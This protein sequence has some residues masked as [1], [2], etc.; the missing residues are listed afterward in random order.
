MFL[1]GKAFEGYGSAIFESR[2]EPRSRVTS[3]FTFPL[4]RE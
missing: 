4:S 3:G 2:V 1:A